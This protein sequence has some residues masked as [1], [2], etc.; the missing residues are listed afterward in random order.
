[1]STRI[2]ISFFVLLLFLAACE[3]E[4][5]RP[6][7][8]L[9]SEEFAEGVFYAHYDNGIDI[10]IKT[11]HPATFSPVSNRNTIDISDSGSVTGDYP[12]DLYWV[13]VSWQDGTEELLP[14]LITPHP[15]Q[16]RNTVKAL[17]EMDSDADDYVLVLR[18]AN[19]DV[20]EDAGPSSSVAEWWKSCDAQLAR[21]I[22]ESGKTRSKLMGDFIK[23]A[24]IP[25]ALGITSE[26][27]RARQTI[28]FMEV[29][30]P[31]QIDGRLNH[32]TY[33]TSPNAAYDDL[34]DIVMENPQE[35]GLLVVVGH[36][37]LKDNNP[38]IDYIHPFNMSDGFLLKREG[39]QVDFVGFVPFEM[40]RLIK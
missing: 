21:Q 2:L 18:H 37:N 9:L 19:A 4:D 3:E 27:C 12:P 38:Y 14:I 7:N 20:G 17:S 10:T 23:N 29:D 11:N 34:V 39:E 25:L 36:S 8:Q 32:E 15:E 35:N 30:V 40:W 26:F 22:G 16:A 1:M 24:N 28:E 31:T 5:N 13:N 33:N 6:D